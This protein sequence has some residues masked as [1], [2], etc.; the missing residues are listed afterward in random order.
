[1]SN[2]FSSSSLSAQCRYPC[3]VL[4][5]WMTRKIVVKCQPS[6]LEK[7]SSKQDKNGAKAPTQSLT[8]SEIVSRRLKTR[9][10]SKYSRPWER[11]LTRSRIAGL[12]SSSSSWVNVRSI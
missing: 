10:I 5:R 1:V 6:N 3:S 11:N 7:L 12:D 2:R 4:N 9:M 8:F